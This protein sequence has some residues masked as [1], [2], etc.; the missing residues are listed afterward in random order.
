[1]PLEHPPSSVQE[2]SASAAPTPTY[3]AAKK[4]VPPRFGYVRDGEMER[5]AALP[6]SPPIQDPKGY[7]IPKRGKK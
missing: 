2:E 4:K 3:G 6:P 5:Y 1:M 7:R